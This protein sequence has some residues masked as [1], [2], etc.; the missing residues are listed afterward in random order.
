MLFNW[1]M[2]VLSILSNLLLV[3]LVNKVK[4]VDLGSYTVLIYVSAVMDVIIAMSK[5]L[6][7]PNIHMGKYSFVVFGVGTWRWPAFPGWSQHF[8]FDFLF[9]QTFCILCYHFV[10]RYMVLQSSRTSS[11]VAELNIWHWTAMGIIFEIICNV[12]MTFFISHYEPRT[13]RKFSDNHQ[14]WRPDAQL[15]ND[16]FNYYGI[17]MSRPFGH[18]HVVYAEV[19]EEDGSMAWNWP[20]VIY[21]L[22]ILGLI[23]MLG[24][25][26]LVCANSVLS[27]MRSLAAD[28][29]IRAS[30]HQQFFRALVI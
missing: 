23:Y 2:A 1:V 10:Y 6:V 26:M 9:Y 27:M 5:A 8:V 11:F 16:M 21:T 20:I 17:N 25:L 4:V 12:I 19:D 18:F 15:V 14:D 22:S 24:V 13:V 7:V 3:L 29:N 28:S 30:T